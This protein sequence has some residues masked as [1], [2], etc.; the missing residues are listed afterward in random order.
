MFMN[1]ALSPWLAILAVLSALGLLAL[2][3][4][5]WHRWSPQHPELLRKL[6][7]L[8]MGCLAASFPWLFDAFWPVLL[9][10]VI[11]VL[12]LIALRV[13]R[14]SV[15]RQPASAAAGFWQ[16]QSALLHG[17]E[18]QSW[19]ELLFPVSI[20]L[21]FFLAQGD[22]LLYSLPILV[23]A[24]A[25]ALAALIGVRYGRM[26]FKTLDG[27]KSLEGSIFFFLVTFLC[28]HLLLLL[29]TETGRFESVL[30]ALLLSGVV[31][32]LE[33]IAWRGLDNLLIPLGVFS[34]LNIYLPLEAG[35][36]LQHLMV[37]LALMLLV[38]GLRHWTSL[39]ANA[40]MGGVLL[41]FAAWGIGD[42]AWL[43]VL[44]VTFVMG[45]WLS[46]QR[47]LLDLRE[48]HTLRLLMAFALPG[49]FW[50]L[51]QSLDPGR[52]FFWGFSFSFAIQLSMMG[53]VHRHWQGAE[54]G[55]S[56]RRREALYSSLWGVGMLLVVLAMELLAFWIWGPVRWSLSG[57][58]SLFAVLLA[59]PL[60]WLGVWS[61]LCWP[62]WM[63]L[64]QD[65]RWLRQAGVAWLLSL[66]G[67]MLLQGVG[68][69]F[70]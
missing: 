61:A 64:T 65:A 38:W 53:W 40:L 69:V 46:I 24:L 70:N 32:L 11:S 19:G 16:Q 62:G 42:E 14:A 41:A 58:H 36:L 2:G 15:T 13:Y 17:V 68:Y 35:L 29:F 20:A 26:H 60:T 30:I 22:P 49:L 8:G 44:L 59:L 50:L 51:L 39:N 18:R 23:L 10:A 48:T 52:L 5:L 47:G 31:M 56:L 43:L 21:L 9:L 66:L 45:S 28:L 33:A 37:L 34:L 1:G 12:G 6:L 25:D 57:P 67:W 63:S 27:H 55:L 54:L 3:L 7:H 4:A